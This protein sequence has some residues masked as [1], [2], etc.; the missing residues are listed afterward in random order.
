MMRICANALANVSLVYL[1]VIVAMRE[2]QR[3]E[4]VFHFAI[5]VSEGF[6]IDADF[7]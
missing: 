2:L 4:K 5:T 6:D 7:L 3:R 1:V